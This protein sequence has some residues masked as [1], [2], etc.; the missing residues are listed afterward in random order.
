MVEYQEMDL[1]RGH[2]DENGNDDKAKYSRSPML[3]LFSL[4]RKVRE[5]L[6]KT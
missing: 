6:D 1:E 2:E 4:Q 3:G 5:N